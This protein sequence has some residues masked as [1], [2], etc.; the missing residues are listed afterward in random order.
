MPTTSPFMLNKGP[1]EFPGFIG[2]SVWMKGTYG[3]SGRYRNVAL[4]IPEVTVP[5]RPNGEPMAITHSPG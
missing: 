4:T 3:F 2:T 1:P 5:S